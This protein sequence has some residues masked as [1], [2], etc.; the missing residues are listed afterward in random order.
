VSAPVADA[1]PV[2]EEDPASAEWRSL[3]LEF[4]PNEPDRAPDVDLDKHE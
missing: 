1:L 2:E 3:P 4:G